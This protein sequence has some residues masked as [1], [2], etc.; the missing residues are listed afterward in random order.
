MKGSR[1]IGAGFLLAVLTGSLG[2][3]GARGEVIEEIVA[4]VNDEIVSRSDLQQEEQE[5]LQDLYRSFTGKDLD[6]RVKVAKAG[7]LLSLID[8]KVLLHRAGRLY[9]M[10]KMADNLLTSFREDRKIKSEDELKMMLDQEHM[11]VAD[12]RRKLLEWTA[13]GEV[14]RYEVRD[15][16][17]VGDKDVEAYYAEHPEVF[18]IPAVA[19]LRE[20]VL[21][22]D[23]DAKRQAR[24]AEAEKLR[25]RAAAPGADF[26]A[27][28]REF[29]EA[30]T[31]ALGGMIADVKKGEL[32][33]PLEEAAFSLPPGQVS[34][35]L[36]RPYGFHILKVESRTET[37]KRPLEEVRAELKAKLYKER[38]EK[39]TEEFLKKARK[40]SEIWVSPKYRD[41]IPPGA[42]EP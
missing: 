35:V 37:R 30:G 4:K 41:R 22:A 3:G 12:L 6:E 34:P 42:L 36:E 5:M 29:S 8:R 38:I 39:A 15:R 24:R 33:V 13:P 2:G 20:I 26:D 21:L 27:L 40:E 23:D 31:R 18:E 7:L 1:G 16:V 17:S 19:T 25:D 9:D 10:D 28:A 11:T 32:A 14:L